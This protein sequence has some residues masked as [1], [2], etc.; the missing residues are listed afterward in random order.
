MNT[1]KL[2]QQKVKQLPTGRPVTF[3]TFASCGS[4]AAVDQA[5]S[6]LVKAGKLSRPARGIYMRPKKNS[7][8]GDVPPEAIEVAKVLAEE[9]GDVV[10][11][12]GAEA[13]RRLGFST[14]VPVRHIFYTTGP[15]RH[16]HLGEMEVT[17]KHVSPRKL[18]MSE[19]LAGVA[20]TALWYLGKKQVT[21][22]TIE[23]LR[24]QLPEEEF[25]T[26]RQATHIMPAWMRAAFV[27]HE[28]RTADD[29]L[30]AHTI[31]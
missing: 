15:N 24:S 6:R 9:F 17:L 16:F 22:E 21:W 28:K 30:L 26:L 18:A 27:D 14:Q 19:R 25:D 2:I 31:K 12:Q 29:R 7:F 13:A 11:I 4:R 3:T 5:L 20:L 23:H 1:S 8:I 10:Q